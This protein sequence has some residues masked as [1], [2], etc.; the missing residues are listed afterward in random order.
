MNKQIKKKTRSDK[1]Q[2][3]FTERDLRVL[4]WIAEQEAARFDQVWTLLER[5]A[6]PRATS[7]CEIRA[8]AV[9]QVIARWQRAG[10]IVQRKV[11][12]EDPPWLWPTARLLRLL[13]LPYKAYEPST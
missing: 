13:E 1:G 9:R 6:G 12:Y 7:E 4:P 2:I 11:F 8:S 10:W 3:T 5:H